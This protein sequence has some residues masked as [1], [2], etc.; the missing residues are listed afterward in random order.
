MAR[1]RGRGGSRGNKRVSFNDSNEGRR[2][3]RAK[4]KEAEEGDWDEPQE[5]AEVPVDDDSGEEGE[6]DMGEDFDGGYALEPFNL[7]EERKFGKFDEKTGGYER[8]RKDEEKEVDAWVAAFEEDEKKNVEDILA[9]RRNTNINFEEPEVKDSLTLQGNLIAL[10]DNNESPRQ[11]MN[12]ISGIQKELRKAKKK[13]ETKEMDKKFGEIT[14][15]TTDLQALGYHG[16]YDESKSKIEK[17]V[18][19]ERQKQEK[20]EN[21]LPAL[22]KSQV[23]WEYK[24]QEGKL[25][26]PYP[27]TDMIQWTDQGYFKGDMAVQIRQI[28][29]VESM[30]DDEP[31]GEESF[32]SS[33]SVDFRQYLK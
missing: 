17:R 19:E 11:A 4:Q 31:E 6:E 23:M 30:F 25:Q 22:E 16:I 27:T 14:D 2:A 15:I 7:K 26:G 20:S 24:D 9:R 18:E 1:G 28:K 3:K 33:D 12:R 13:E 21:H 5:D 8:Q 29:Q 10:L 32:V